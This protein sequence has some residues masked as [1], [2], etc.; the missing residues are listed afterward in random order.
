MAIDANTGEMVERCL[1]RAFDAVPIGLAILAGGPEGCGQFL[2]VNAAMADLFDCLP[3][4][5]L[6]RSLA[7]HL[8]ADERLRYEEFI[9]RLLATHQPA[10]AEFRAASETSRSARRLSVSA[11]V[12][13]D[14]ESGPSQIVVSV[15]DVSRQHDAEGQLIHLALHD[16]VTGLP[17]RLLFADR[18]GQALSRAHRRG[19]VAVILVDID[20]FA[21]VNEALGHTAGDQVLS[22]VA[23]RLE[24]VAG[25]AATVARLGS[26]EFL[27]LIE[28]FSSDDDALALAERME[29]AIAEPLV[30]DGR[31]LFVT[32]SIGVAVAPPVT[33]VQGQ[34]PES[35][36]AGAKVATHRVKVAK[37]GGPALFHDSM[38]PGP[39]SRLEIGS[40]LQRAVERSELRAVY[41]PLYSLLTGRIIG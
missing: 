17:N 4:E 5:L 9:S 36:L 30:V 2:D 19:R 20:R 11:S 25:A 34:D 40:R 8:R 13:R 41:Q 6:G 37:T 18:V 33:T 12:V 38:R 26:D 1:R 3:A 35:L 16:H 7:D 21:Q 31:E 32:A 27:V 28:G 29:R 23:K 14:A 15:E 39:V 22:E 24:S 10:T